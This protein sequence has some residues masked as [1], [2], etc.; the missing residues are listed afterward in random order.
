M[1][2]IGDEQGGIQPLVLGDRIFINEPFA[3]TL[4]VT[5]LATLSGSYSGADGTG[6]IVI[7]NTSTLN[8]VPQQSRVDV[9]DGA[10]VPTTISSTFLVDSASPFFDFSTFVGAFANTGTADFANTA[11]YS[12]LLPAGFT[13]SS[14]SGVF[15]TQRTSSA[16]EPSTLLLLVC[17]G[18]AMGLRKRRRGSFLS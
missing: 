2:R 5:L 10:A 1:H 8:T 13:F 4:S 17:G 11:V 9:F 12:V 6:F 3:G 18:A 16:P 15:L 14:D 7:M